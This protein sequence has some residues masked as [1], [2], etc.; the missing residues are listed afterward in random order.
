MASFLQRSKKLNILTAAKEVEATG[1]R[2]P[3]ASYL[4]P[5]LPHSDHA[6][7]SSERVHRHDFSGRHTSATE[8]GEQASAAQAKSHPDPEASVPPQ[9]ASLPPLANALQV[10]PHT[11]DQPASSKQPERLQT[12]YGS[13]S[14]ANGLQG[15]SAEQKAGEPMPPPPAAPSTNVSLHRPAMDPAKPNTCPVKSCTDKQQWSHISKQQGQWSQN[16]SQQADQWEPAPSQTF[17]QAKLACNPSFP[18]G[19]QP[20][21]VM[22]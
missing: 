18:F 5:A 4:I 14:A 13:A 2:P 16:R 17:M 19:K 8:Q 22:W 7:C 21:A 1:S 9:A 10:Q 15:S 6:A 12:G 20:C 3:S 11:S